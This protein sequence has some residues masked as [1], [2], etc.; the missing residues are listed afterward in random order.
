MEIRTNDLLNDRVL[1]NSVCRGESKRRIYLCGK[2]SGVER[3]RIYATRVEADCSTEIV[4][5]NSVCSGESKRR[6]Y[7]CGKP[8]AFPT[9]TNLCHKILEQRGWTFLETLIVIAIISVLSAT[10]G[11]TAIN[12]LNRA[13][14]TA[15][16]TQIDSFSV[17]LESYYVDC[18]YY[19]TTEQGLSALYRKPTSEPTSDRWNGPYILK[20]TPEDPWGHAYD[21]FNPGPEG[22]SYGIR[23][24]GADGLE[25]GDGN[26]ADIVSW[27][28][29]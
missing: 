5:R 21:Y 23:S 7:L 12:A 3:K 25:G 27:S 28:A 14:R 13:R 17:A 24:F 19:P 4:S 1:K 16:T 15:A 26:N 9:K 29:N 8:S 22:F 6:I 2:P 11:F 10:V 18:G 20:D